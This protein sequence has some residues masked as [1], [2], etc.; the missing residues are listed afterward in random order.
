MIE[1]AYAGKL[2]VFWFIVSLLTVCLSL[3][4][5]VGFWPIWLLP[6]VVENFWTYLIVV[7]VCVN[8]ILKVLYTDFLYAVSYTKLQFGVV[9]PDFWFV[10]R[11]LFGPTCSELCLGLEFIR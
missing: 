11:R 6:S 8:V 9:F 1:L 7:F 10:F 4:E 2:N 3:L 5:P